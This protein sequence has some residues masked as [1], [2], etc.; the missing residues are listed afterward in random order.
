MFQNICLFIVKKKYIITSFLRL[1]ADFHSL[2]NVARSEM[3]IPFLCSMR[4]IDK[5][6][7]ID[8]YFCD[9]FFEQQ[10]KLYKIVERATFCTEWKSAFIH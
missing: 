3:A 1:K 9:R 7:R 4:S 10:I 5:T 8:F 6:S 2:K